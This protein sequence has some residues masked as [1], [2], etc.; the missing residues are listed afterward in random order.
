MVAFSNGAAKAIKAELQSLSS[1]PHPSLFDMLSSLPD[2]VGAAQKGDSFEVPSIADFTIYSDGSTDQT[3]N[4][5]SLSA[6]TLTIDQEPFLPINITRRRQKQLLGGGNW[7]QQLAI[8]ANSQIRNYLDRDVADYL[9]ELAYDSSATYYTNVGG[10]TLTNTMLLEAAAALAAQRGATD[11]IA[12]VLDAYSEAQLHS[13]AGFLYNPGQIQM[14]VAG[15]RQVGMLHGRPVILTNENPGSAA[16]GAYTVATTAA[17]TSGSGT[18]HTYTVAAGHNLVPGMY[19]T[20]SGHDADENISTAA[21]ITSV[22][23]TSVVVTTSATA[24]G[25]SSDASG[26]ITLRSAL[27]FVVDFGHMWKGMSDEIMVR[28]VDQQS[29]TG[30]RL[31]I[32][33][34]YGMIGRAGR[35][36][37]FCSPRASLTQS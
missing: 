8:E 2:E 34:L 35:V 15:F 26:T 3:A 23:A 13:L 17:V 1:T 11:K 10:L 12:Y 6:L 22:G 25:T 5:P 30:S 31:H 21:A 20:V 33:P 14:G 27:N 37:A 32:S 16:R 7:A 4:D 19:V 29:N 28:L 9:F 36:R 18:I 24:D